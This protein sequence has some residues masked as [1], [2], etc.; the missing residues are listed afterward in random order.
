MLGEMKI[1]QD[2]TTFGNMLC[3]YASQSMYGQLCIKEIPK[4]LTG[5]ANKAITNI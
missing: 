5:I 3:I 4:N 1:D 2:F